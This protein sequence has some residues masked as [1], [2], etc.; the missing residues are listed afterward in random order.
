MQ[1]L[2]TLGQA[3]LPNRVVSSRV[4]AIIAIGW[5][6]TALLVWVNSPFEVLPTPGDV[7]AAFPELWMNQGLSRELG[8]SFVL[9]IEAIAI[10]SIFSFG[11][12]YATVLPLLR[13]IV[14]AVSKGRFLGLIGLPFLF[15]ILVG[16]GRPL[17]L[18]LLV[19]GIS[20]FLVTTM[21]DEVANIARDRFDLARTLRMS[22]WRVV[23]EV[24]VLGTVDRAIDALRQNAAIGW[25]MLPMVEGISR[26]QGGVGAMLLDQNKHFHLASIFAVQLTLLAIGLGQDACFGFMKRIVCP[27]AFFTLERR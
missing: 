14:A 23:W 9:Y 20:V 24:V 1:V 16:T 12:S 21:A 7:F 10:A 22:E 25:M 3:F 15:T 26:T 2:R 19:C 4:M 18:A 11:V 13:P 5:T 8:T 17:K 27:Y 6:M